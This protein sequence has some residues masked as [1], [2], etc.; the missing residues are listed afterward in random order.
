MLINPFA[1]FF[2][3]AIVLLNGTPAIIKAMASAAK[4]FMGSYGNRI[5]IC[6]G[7]ADDVE[8]NAAITALPATGGR[9]V[10]SEGTFIGAGS[11]KVIKPLVIEGQGM[12][13]GN[14]RDW[15]TNGIT[16]LTL[17]NGVNDDVIRKEP[18]ADAP[19]TFWHTEIKN[20][21]ING[22]K[23]NQASGHGINCDYLDIQVLN[24]RVRNC[25]QNGINASLDYAKNSVWL[26]NCQAIRNGG[27]GFY[28]KS[29]GMW[30]KD[31]YAGGNGVDGYY[32][33]G[34]DCFISA[35]SEDNTRFGYNAHQLAQSF[36]DLWSSGNY[37]VGVYLDN[38][39]GSY[40][41]LFGKANRLTSPGT[42]PAEMTAFNVRHCTID[43]IAEIYSAQAADYRAFMVGDKFT[44][45]T[46]R[47]NLRLNENV[48]DN[49]N[50][51]GL[52][53]AN[54]GTLD[55]TGTEVT[56]IINRV[57]I[58]VEFGVVAQRRKVRLN[59]QGYRSGADDFTEVLLDTVATGYGT[60]HVNGGF[61]TASKVAMFVNTSVTANSRGMVFSLVGLINTSASSMNRVDLSKRMVISCSIA[62]NLSDAQVVRRIQLKQ[63]N[64]EGA[65]AAPGLGIKV[66]NKALWGESYGSE[67]GEIDLATSL[68]DDTAYKLEIV[69]DP[70]AGKIEW[71]VNNVLKGTQATVAKVPTA[72]TGDG[73]YVISIINGAT[74]GVNAI[75]WSGPITI[76]QWVN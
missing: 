42:H 49:S 53:F 58:P 25:K 16:T 68:A 62:A 43:A 55:L 34:G 41:K 72:S 48:G 1:L 31:V 56:G 47:V 17:A 26:L 14:I 38:V 23:A 35:E 19:N 12:A 63:A 36:A 46:V 21:C 44:H 67:N 57:A 33:Y 51:K 37:D 5:Q 28:L 71:Y 75:L 11:I 50:T 24:V 6:D 13:G 10:L 29:Q 69:H 76:R 4:V 7:V 40:L 66:V 3:T 27:T 74:G 61:S 52:V 15:D 45:N 30:L 2:S 18:L 64:T 54:W 22:N 65:L 20:L 73:Y 59:I 39:Y 60:S 8:M 32:L 9:I 70:D